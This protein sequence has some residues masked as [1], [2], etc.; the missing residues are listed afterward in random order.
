MKRM[1]KTGL[2]LL[3]CLLLPFTGIVSMAGQWEQNSLGIWSYRYWDGDLLKDNWY[4]IDGD[5]DGTAECYRFDEQGYMYQNTRT[6]DGYTVDDTGAWIVDEVRQLKPIERENTGRAFEHAVVNGSVLSNSWSDYSL[7][8]PPGSDVE[9]TVSYRD[10]KKTEPSF[11]DSV[12]QTTEEEGS[13]TMYIWYQY[14]REPGMPAADQIRKHNYDLV[15]SFR[16]PESFVEMEQSVGGHI[17]S[18]TRFYG[19]DVGH[20]QFKRKID[21]MIMNVTFSYPHTA[22]SEDKVEQLIESIMPEGSRK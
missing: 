4:W 15:H 17:F 21:D 1:K 10:P 12:I 7:I 22:K 2:L 18:G 19:W 5:L 9:P 16:Y 13:F 20:I 3:V 6:P 8:I 11:Y 14:D